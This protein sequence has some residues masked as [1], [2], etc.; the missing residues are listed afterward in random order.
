MDGSP[1]IHAYTVPETALLNLDSMTLATATPKA[2]ETLSPFLKGI[3]DPST[4]ISGVV[5]LLEPKQ[6]ARFIADLSKE[7]DGKAIIYDGN[8]HD[9]GGKVSS[10]PVLTAPIKSTELDPPKADKSF[11]KGVD[12]EE[13]YGSPLDA[14]TAQGFVDMPS[15]DMN[16]K[17]MDLQSRV[18]EVL[19]EI[20]DKV[21]SGFI[22]DD[23]LKSFEGIKSA[24]AK[25]QIQEDVARAFIF[26]TRGNS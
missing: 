22:D 18:D 26:C 2:M 10:S 21:Q 5:K 8:I 19:N 11:L 1:E 20:K 17:V 4:K 23:M 24:D 14:Q 25:F 7:N 9:F 15:V 6:R 16:P 13:R 12:K 3:K